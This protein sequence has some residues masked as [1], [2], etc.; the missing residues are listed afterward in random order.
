M[1]NKERLI[2]F[3]GRKLRG[4]TGTMFL[5]DN[6]SKYAKEDER[7]SWKNISPLIL[8]PIFSNLLKI[9]YLAHIE[10]FLSKSSA[11]F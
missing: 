5:I 2:V 11:I 7:R 4:I 10:Y 9:F 6:A 8:L 3:S 1:L